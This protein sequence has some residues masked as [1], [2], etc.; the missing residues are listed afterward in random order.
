VCLERQFELIEKTLGS[1]VLVLVFVPVVGLFR[2]FPTQ[3]LGLQMKLLH[4]GRRRDNLRLL[5]HLGLCTEV[6]EAVDNMVA[7]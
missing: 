5:V 3:R 1:M 4:G 2:D 6:Q 7:G